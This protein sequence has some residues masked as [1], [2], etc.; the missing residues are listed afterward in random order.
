MG[1]PPLTVVVPHYGDPLSPAPLVEALL[2]QREAPELQIVVVDDAS[3]VAYPGR[4]G[5]TVVRRDVNGGFG[6]AVNSGAAVAEGELLLLLN[7]DLGIRETFVRDLLTAA[8][9]WLPAVV[10]PRVV[11][12]DGEE[13]YSGRYFPRIRHQAAEWLTPLARWRGTR[14]WHEAVGHDLAARGTDSLVDWA[15]GAALLVPLADFRAVGGFDE[16][17]FMNAEEIDLQ[18][19]LRDR[20]LPS[21]VL[22]APTAVHAG[23]GSSDPALRRRWLTESRLAYADKWGGRRR[24]QAALTAASGVNLAWNAG[25]RA[26]GADVDPAQTCRDELDLVRPRSRR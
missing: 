5:V 1:Q 23:G 20:G 12:E 9:P 10:S 17:F 21:V 25:R 19:R 2:A 11:D 14:A 22:S 8:E 15:V 26:A 6:S 18:R 4:S 16:R 24:L 13:L 3:A 7:S